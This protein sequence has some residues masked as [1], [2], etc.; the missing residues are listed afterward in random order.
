[1]LPLKYR[2]ALHCLRHPS[3]WRALTRRVAPSIEHA[4]ALRHLRFR[5]IVD[6]GANRGQFALFARLLNPSAAIIVFEPLEAPRAVLTELLGA[7]PRVRCH[8]VAV[9]ALSHDATFFVTAKD[10]SSSL[11]PVADRQREIF[12][13]VESSTATVPVRRLSQVV[14]PSD[15]EEPSLL[16][17]DVQGSELDVLRGSEDLLGR[18]AAI[19]VECSYL[20]LY[21]NQALAKDV[22]SWLEER[23]FVLG[24]VF[25]QHDHPGV[26]PVQADFLFLRAESPALAHGAEAQPIRAIPAAPV[27]SRV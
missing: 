3:L 12:G 24:G 25:N 18:F 9:G 7:D 17:I 1:M 2:K 8:G 23:G 10:D 21:Q 4:A 19:Y 27:Q 5:T 14:S 13:T 22:I 15:L 20:P 6:I 26:G 16:K 11:L